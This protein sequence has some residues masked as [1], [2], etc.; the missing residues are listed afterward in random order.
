MSKVVTVVIVVA[1]SVLFIVGQIMLVVVADHVVQR[2]PVVRSHKVDAAIRRAATGLIEVGRASQ[3]RGQRSAHPFFAQP[4][5]THVVTK[6]PIP[7]GPSFAG[8]ERSDLV[9]TSRVPG[10]GNDLGV[11]QH[12]I[13]GDRFDQR[14]V[15]DQ[16]AAAVAAENR[17]KVESEAIDVIVVNPVT[18]AVKN[19]LTHDR[20]VSVN[21]VAAAGIVFVVVLVVFQHVVDGILQ[22]F[23]AE[24]RSLVI[25]LAGV[26]EHD[27]K[28]D[29]DP[30]FVQFLDHLFELAHLAT[31]RLVG[32][33]SAMRCEE[34]H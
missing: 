7:F 32:C 33:V 1:V 10:F 28:D 21:R 23:E 3:P 17:G 29:L 8:T 30:G 11:G 24:R 19:H 6:T 26:I 25:A 9:G 20:M 22:S 14:R 4:V 18:Q 13:F 27:V 34:G 31:G 15:G 12:R 16:V 2:E 5:P